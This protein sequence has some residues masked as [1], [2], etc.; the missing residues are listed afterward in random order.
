MTLYIVKREKPVHV[1]KFTEINGVLEPLEII[2]TM[3]Y[4]DAFQ[5]CQTRQI[6]TSSQ[7]IYAPHSVAG[8]NNLMVDTFITFIDSLARSVRSKDVEHDKFN[9]YKIKMNLNFSP[10]Y[11]VAGLSRHSDDLII[12]KDADKG[13]GRNIMEFAGFNLSAPR[14]LY[15]YVKGLYD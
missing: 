1:M 6:E 14:V 10:R 4:A 11:V 8:A 13:K 15:L 3:K 12:E 2:P 9:D 7:N 5:Y